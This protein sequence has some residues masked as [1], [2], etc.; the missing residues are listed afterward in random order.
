[1]Q[2]IIDETFDEI[3]VCYNTNTKKYV[4]VN[5]W[6]LLS[7]NIKTYYTIGQFN[8]LVMDGDLID[9]DIDYESI[10]TLLPTSNVRVDLFISPEALDDMRNWCGQNNSG[11]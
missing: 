4:Y 2:T 10:L 7:H 9:V 5:A 6:Y 3:F 1:M 11:N 8:K